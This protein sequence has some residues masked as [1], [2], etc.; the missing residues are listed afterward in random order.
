M[1]DFHSHLALDEL[2]LVEELVEPVEELEELDDAL[3][4]DSSSLEL[5]RE[6][7][8]D[9]RLDLTL[10]GHVAPQVLELCVVVVLDVE[11]RRLVHRVLSHSLFLL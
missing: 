9:T 6:M 7:L 10:G 5:L 4:L 1:E 2:E 8:L 11:P 3:L